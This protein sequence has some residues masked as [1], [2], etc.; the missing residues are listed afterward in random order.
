MPS[1]ADLQADQDLIYRVAFGR[2]ADV[3][4]LLKNGADPRTL[5][6]ADMPAIL[7]AVMNRKS[8]DPETTGIVKALLDAGADPNTVGPNG[9]LLLIEAVKNS[10]AD[11]VATIIAHPDAVVTAKDR[12][13][14]TLLALAQDRKDEGIIAAVQK[15]LDAEVAKSQQLRS[16]EN[17]TKLIQQYAFLSCANEYL[18]FYVGMDSGKN[19]DAV[20]FKTVIDGNQAEVRATENKIKKIFGL[21]S[22]YLREIEGDSKYKISTELKGMGSDRQRV[23]EGVGSDYD[24]NKRCRRI[25]T[26]WKAPKPDAPQAQKSDIRFE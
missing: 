13:G 11:V 9:E 5:N 18:N 21:S 14:K 20:S 2:S 19:M 16:G 17:L 6:A 22:S 25:A 23:F 12:Y 3:E 8:G 10:S 15:G 4:V 24:L 7:V 1:M 26:K